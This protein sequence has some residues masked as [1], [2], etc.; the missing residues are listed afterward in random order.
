MLTHLDDLLAALADAIGTQHYIVMGTLAIILISLICGSV[1]AMVIGNRMAFFADALAHC[2]FAG[3]GLGILTALLT[4][5][6]NEQTIDW[7]LP[8]IMI[9][10]GVLVGIGIAFVRERTNLASD[11]V[12]GVFFAAAVGFAGV[13][14]GALKLVTNKSPENMM[15]GSVF[16]VGVGDL[17]L[18]LGL[19]VLTAFV[20]GLRYNQ[21]VFA[22]FNPSLARS[23]QIPVRLL[24]YV[25]IVLLGVIVNVCIQAV[26]ILLINA[27]LI[28]PA[29]AAVNLSRNLRQMF[30]LTIVMSLLAGLGGIL[31]SINFRP[32][33]GGIVVQLGA[34]GC[35]VLLSVLFFAMSMLLS[36]RLRRAG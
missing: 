31:L 23:R 30:W 32:H 28:V 33:F 10:F 5:V 8:V 6:R 3:V 12:I 17:L 14:M 4:G 11:T 1:G 36:P 18:L 22:S 13:L 15:F 21:L 16:Y 9:S 35:I 7:L 34:G 19:A 20:I 27:M 25:F 2:A 24:N 26:G 29:A